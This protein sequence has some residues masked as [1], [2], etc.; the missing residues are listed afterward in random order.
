MSLKIKLLLHT[1]AELRS[2]NKEEKRP[3]GANPELVGGFDPKWKI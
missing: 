2:C 3:A 1:Q